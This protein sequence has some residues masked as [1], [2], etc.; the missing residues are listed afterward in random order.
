MN[1]E[2]IEKQLHELKG[3]HI[4]IR[5]ANTV[6]AV[7]LSLS[8]TDEQLVSIRILYAGAAEGGLEGL[9]PENDPHI[10][11]RLVSP[12]PEE[13]EKYVAV[14]F[15]KDTSGDMWAHYY[16]H[17]YL[18]DPAI[19]KT[20]LKFVFEVPEILAVKK[21]LIEVFVNDEKLYSETAETPGIYTRIIDVS[22]VYA[23]L[24]GYIA[25]TRRRQD[26]LLGEFKRIC[27]KYQIPWYLICGGLIGALRDGDLIPW[28]DDL[29]IAV[30]RE[31]YEKLKAAVAGEWS[32]GG[33]FLWLSPGDYGENVFFDFM[34]RIVYMAE[35]S[36][37]DVFARLG[38]SGRQ[39][40]RHRE[41]L[42]IYILD[43]AFDNP[44]LHRL[45][46]GALQLLYVLSLG[47]RPGFRLSDHS[48]HGKLSLWL[49]DLFR[50]AGRRISLRKLLALFEKT[51]VLCRSSKGRNYFMSNGYYRCI[52]MRFRKEWFG[53]G[54]PVKCGND[55][56]R[57]PS[58]A[59]GF[60]RAMYGDYQIYPFPWHREP[61]HF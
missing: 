35:E 28:D 44:F 55:F 53:K 27:G 18:R 46:T 42:D 52:P 29:D 10:Y 31:G 1:T 61:K 49:T 39:D 37:G 21:P 45:Q 56:F 6:K 17:I 25:E 5:S 58:D 13:P 33:G 23:K 4:V 8:E 19:L 30:T 9:H 16:S 50:R 60:L 3:Y 47:H 20:G 22:K 54:Q 59:H 51:A 57:G 36:E 15:F 26:I 41:I 11:T 14:G 48:D 38:A 40:I 32:A 2:R 7:R 12:F 34:T 43:N 24:A